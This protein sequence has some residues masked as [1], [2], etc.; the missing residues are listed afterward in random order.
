MAEIDVENEEKM[1][2][3]LAAGALYVFFGILQALA[4]T[5]L[6]DIPLVPGN[7]IGVLV[8]VVIGAV[9]LFGYRELKE[10]IPE[11]IA[12][13]HVGIGLS[14]V[15]GIIYLL[16]MGADAISAYLIRSEDFE[17]WSIIDDVRPEL[18]LALL[19]L[20][21]LVKWRDEFSLKGITISGV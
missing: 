9:F 2:F 16:V 13:I 20:I 5:G 6:V 11:G 15:F 1:T 18:Y 17:D 8:L 14:L 19:S 21:G 3:G 12:Y 7:A 4:S 10:G